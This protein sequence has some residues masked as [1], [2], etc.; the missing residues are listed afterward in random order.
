MSS[1]R[2]DAND[3]DHARLVSAQSPACTIARYSTIVIEKVGQANNRSKC[4][5]G[6]RPPGKCASESNQGR[7]QLSHF[8]KPVPA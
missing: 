6:G 2:F 7:N 5:A 1:P 4:P 3:V 8:Q